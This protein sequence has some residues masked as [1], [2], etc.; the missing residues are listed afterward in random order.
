LSL[1]KLISFTFL[2]AFPP[3]IPRAVILPVSPARLTLTPARSRE[4]Q[5][6]EDSSVA[7]RLARLKIQYE[8]TGIR[9]SVDAVM[10]VMVSTPLFYR[11][12]IPTFTQDHGL[13]HI[14]VLQVASGF[15]KL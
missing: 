5:P 12:P 6:E 1:R 4:T 11:L 3:V 13:P 14:L 15:F 9:R 8:E 10:V 7:E 2:H